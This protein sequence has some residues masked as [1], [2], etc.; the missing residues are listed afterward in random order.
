MVESEALRGQRSQRQAA[1]GG[2]QAG[3]LVVL[4][5]LLR[6]GFSLRGVHSARVRPGGGAA[7]VERDARARS[8]AARCRNATMMTR[9]TLS[10]S[11]I[12]MNMRAGHTPARR[13]R[14]NYTAPDSYSDVQE[15]VQKYPPGLSSFCYVNPGNPGEAVLERDSLLIGLVLLF[16]LIFVVIGAGGIYFTW[17]RQPPEEARPIAPVRPPAGR[18][19][20]G[21]AW[22]ASS[23][24][25]RS[26]AG[27]MFYLPGRPADRPDSRRTVVGRDAVHGAAGRGPQPRQRRRDDLQRVHPVRIRIRR[28][29]L[30]ERPLRLH[31]R[32]VPAGTRARPASWP[33]TR[34]PR[35]P[36]AMSIR[37]IRRSRS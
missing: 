25:S 16:P 28:A 22:Q 5:F 29:D 12:S 27:A 18:A 32:V 31:R 36:S 1:V 26:S 23:A 3:R 17:R 4:S 6:D 9:P 20:A 33:S 19:W 21:T 14:R 35:D 24:S 8:S 10:P 2:R 30:Q 34:R 7:G 37:R 15:L 11:A 13:T